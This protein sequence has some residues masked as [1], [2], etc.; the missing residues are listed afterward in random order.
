MFCLIL[1]ALVY[2]YVHI[3]RCDFYLMYMSFEGETFRRRG[4]PPNPYSSFYRDKSL[5]LYMPARGSLNFTFPPKFSASDF[6]LPH[7]SWSVKSEHLVTNNGLSTHHNWLLALKNL[8]LI[9]ETEALKLDSKCLRGVHTFCIPDQM[10]CTT[11]PQYG[12]DFSLVDNSKTS[13]IY[14]TE[15][16]QR[17]TEQANVIVLQSKNSDIYTIVHSVTTADDHLN[18]GIYTPRGQE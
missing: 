16:R 6:V 1:R 8:E 2:W 14:G 13:T 11:L 12:I 4:R 17:D 9:S 18:N 3:K 5:Q 10:S 15:Q 7:R